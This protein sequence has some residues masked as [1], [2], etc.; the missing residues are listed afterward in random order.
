M[1]GAAEHLYWFASEETPSYLHVRMEQ[2]FPTRKEEYESAQYP[3]ELVNAD[4]LAAAA[5][6]QEEGDFAP[7]AAAL[8]QDAQITE[9]VQALR[10]QAAHQTGGLQRDTVTGMY[11]EKI[12]LSASQIQTFAACRQA[13]F[14][15]YG[16]KA[17]KRA[18]AEFDAPIYGTFVHE[19]LE[20]TV[21][22]VQGEGGFANVAAERVEE[23]ARVHIDT[24][25]REHCSQPEQQTPRFVYLYERNFDEIMQVIREL[26]E[27]LRGC[28]FVP[29]RFE[30]PFRTDAAMGPVE[31][32]GEK[33]IAQV[34]GAVDRVD[35]LHAPHGDFVRV[36]DYK[37]GL[38]DFDYTDILCGMG[39][40]MLIYLFALEENGH[41]EFGY[42]VK[43]A[44]VLYFPARQNVML[45]DMLADDTTVTQAR[46]TDLKRKGLLVD[47]DYLLQA[48]EKCDGSPRFL[49][50]KVVKEKRTGDLAD[51]HQLQLLRRHVKRTLAQFADEIFDGN[52]TPNPYDRGQHNACKYCDYAQICRKTPEQVRKLQKTKPADF[53]AE[54]E[55]KEGDDRG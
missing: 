30:L 13:H 6:C 18:Q 20:K 19:V 16:I 17:K 27:E 47:D 35:V 49:P 43:P 1:Q 9:R 12:F 28:E 53:W 48:M 4:A 44:G 8:L 38:K 41:R 46:Q 14:L 5:V 29:E 51:S 40:Q 32:R 26:D 42:P 25:T 39:L 10:K 22:Q 15:Q 31:I 50:Y 45:T 24:F 2:L 11:G 55:R 7:Q 54:L 34:S 21:K 37:T 23:I 36:V 52:I 3:A 33:G